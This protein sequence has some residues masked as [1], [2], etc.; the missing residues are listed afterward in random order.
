MPYD[1]LIPILRDT[2]EKGDHAI[3]IGHG[4][5]EFQYEQRFVWLIIFLYNQSPLRAI[6]RVLHLDFLGQVI[7]KLLVIVNLLIF[8]INVQQVFEL[9]KFL[10]GDGLPVEGAH[11]L[12]QSLSHPGEGLDLLF[13]LLQDF[14]GLE[15]VESVCTYKL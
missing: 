12:S 9:L 15:F 8:E 11:Q 7:R 3:P 4:V 10:V 13:E 14:L 1:D 6:E 5:M 2:R